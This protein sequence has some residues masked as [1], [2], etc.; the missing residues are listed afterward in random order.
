[1][2]DAQIDQLLNV[3]TETI[4][5][6]EQSL[7]DELTYPRSNSI[8]VFGAGNLGRKTASGLRKTGI[9]PLAF[10]DNNRSFWNKAIDG[11]KV[12]SPDDAAQEFGQS[13]VFVIAV[14]SQGVDRRISYIARTLR[15]LGCEKVVSF[16]PLFWKYSDLFLPH[17]RLNLPHLIYQQA[18]NV[19]KVFSMLADDVSRSEYLSQL[20]WLLSTDFGELSALVNHKTYLP[21][22]IFALSPHEVF[23]DCGA[24]DGDTI[25]TFL[26]HRGNVFGKI[27]A[28]E[29]D[30]LNFSKLHHYVSRLPKVI[31]DRITMWQLATGARRETLRFDAM[32]TVASSISQTGT[33][34]V[35]CVPLDEMLADC[36]PTYIKMDIEGAEPAALVGGRTI[37]RETSPVLAICVYHQQD[38]LWKLPLLMQSL[39]PERYHFFLRRYDDEFGDLVCY[40][41]PN[42]RLRQS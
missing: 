29:P 42:Y 8:V 5:R 38:H 4:I 17:C 22:E 20:K 7:Y 15:D 32:G 10:V 39:L 24:Y 31:S 3:D 26:R 27:V 41:V 1:M 23:I 14:W 35:E 9:E 25:R 36:V 33:L 11:I 37:I 6:R 30:P 16:V 40:A 12:F 2:L 19:R 28:F 18:D 21:D 34:E 13:A